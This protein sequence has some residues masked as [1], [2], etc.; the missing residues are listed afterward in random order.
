MLTISGLSKRSGYLCAALSVSALA[1][2]SDDDPSNPMQSTGALAAQDPDTAPQAEID[3]FSAAAGTLQVRS[4][5]NGL[6]AAGAPVDFDRAPFI[7][8]GLGP[9]GERVRYYNFDV[10]SNE[11][12]PIYVLA[13]EGENQP[14]PGQLNIVDVKPGDAGYNDFWRVT[15]VTVPAD[16]VA[17]SVTSVEEIM[18]SG[19][20]LSATDSLV[21][22]PVV[23]QGS[24]ARL[25]LEEGSNELHRGWYRG[26]VLYYFS[27]EEHAL[28]GN[29]VPSAPI[30]V[31]FNINPDLDGG[32]PPSGFKEESGTDQ[33]H[34]V[35]SALP[36]S[37]GY[38]PLWAVSPYDNADFDVV[39]DLSSVTNANVLANDVAD[40]NCPI[41]QID[42]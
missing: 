40:V 6:P 29:T 21:N 28:S 5:S 42:Q 15:M 31:S 38:S 30:Y 22:C 33:T 17:N 14:V 16:Y 1:C 37:A 32:G 26:Q 18:A 10:K 39:D 7:T 3:R 4:A 24:R 23:P 41:V 27:F 9:S 8:S 20:A 12:A 36:S 11:P 35:V 25:R 19:Y 13:R 2:G 34:N